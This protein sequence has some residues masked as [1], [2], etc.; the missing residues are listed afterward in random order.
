MNLQITYNKIPKNFNKS[1]ICIYGKLNE[2]FKYLFIK[3]KFK[4]EET[5]KFTNI[6]FTDKCKLKIIDSFIPYTYLDG[7]SPNLNKE[8]HIGHFSNLVIAKSFK[9]L[10]IAKKTVAMLGDT[11][12]TGLDN[13]KGWILIKHF[14]YIFNYKIDKLYKASKLKWINSY[15]SKGKDDYKGTKI[16]HF[17]S[18]TD[19]LIKQD[20]STSYIYHDLAL[21]DKLKKNTLY[22]TGYEQKEHFSKI[23]EVFNT[24][25]HLPLGLVKISNSKM[26]SRENNVILMRDVIDYLNSLFNNNKIVYNVFA[27]HILKSNPS[28]D[29]NIDFKNLANLKTSLGLY[30]SYTMARLHKAGC[31][32]IPTFLIKT[33]KNLEFAKIQ[34]RIQLNPSLLFNEIID[35]CKK[36]NTLYEKNRIKGTIKNKLT[37]SNNLSN[38]IMYTKMLGLYN[39]KY[40]HDCKN[41][42]KSI[43]RI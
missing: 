40:I 4:I 38:L 20:M 24:I 14:L 26:A 35:F 17:N 27:G 7:F 21:A 34:S 41:K 2:Y 3:N 22:L 12:S 39:I 19:V 1:G 28:S 37:M 42:H 6:L 16:M 30:I 13:K 31:I 11:L 9:H 43:K 5:E 36:L 29:K 25:H 10:K 32:K 18:S 23:K 15:L 8:L 33:N